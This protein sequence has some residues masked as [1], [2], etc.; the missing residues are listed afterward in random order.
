MRK[1]FFLKTKLKTNQN[2][3]TKNKKQQNKENTKKTKQIVWKQ[4]KIK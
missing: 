1:L 4:N 2:N 3:E